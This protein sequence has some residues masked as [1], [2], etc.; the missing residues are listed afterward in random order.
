[1]THKWRKN[2]QP[3]E[4]RSCCF[5]N[6]IFIKQSNVAIWWRCLFIHKYKFPV[7]CA[8]YECDWQKIYIFLLLSQVERNYCSYIW[9]QF[10]FLNKLFNCIR[11]KYLRHEVIMIVMRIIALKVSILQS[12]KVENPVKWLFF[13]N[14]HTQHRTCAKCA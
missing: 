5:Y 4:R 10:W 3:I 8:K 7:E 12:I 14:Y 11:I 1:M 2:Q 13:C 9:S 6:F